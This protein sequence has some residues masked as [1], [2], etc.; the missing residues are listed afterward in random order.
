MAAVIAVRALFG[1]MGFTN[2]VSNYLVTDQSLDSLDE[3]ALLT[4][5]DIDNLCS[6]V[7]RPGGTIGNNVPNPGLNVSVRA[8]VNMKLLV[9]YTQHMLRRISRILNATNIQLADVQRLTYMKWEEEN[10]TD[11]IESP[12]IDAKD[13]PKT[14]E[15]IREHL[16]NHRSEIGV[17]LSYVVRRTVN[18][19]PSV[20]DPSD[21]YLDTIDEMVAR[22]PH[23]EGGNAAP[24]YV[25]DNDKVWTIISNLCRDEP[26]WTYVKPSQSARNGR[27]AFYGL[28]DQYLG[29]NNVDNMANMAELKLESSSYHGERRGWNFEKYT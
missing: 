20:D 8:Q 27:G 19:L 23:E 26:C 10:Y 22:A 25:A 18:V 13:W 21:N 14:L 29:P 11:P 12:K 7:R 1:R 24:S 2:E 9:Y 6:V 15:A 16:R 28:Y 3:I 5:K 4:N 17:P